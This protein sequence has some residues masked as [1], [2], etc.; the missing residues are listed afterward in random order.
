MTTEYSGAAS[1]GAAPSTSGQPGSNSGSGAG[2]TPGVPLAELVGITKTFGALV[3]NDSIDL[4]VQPGEVLALLGENGAGKST[5]T[6]ILYGLSQADRGEIRINGVP[7]RM[8]SP[9]DAMAAGIGMVTQEFSL[10]GTMTVTENLMLAGVG[11]GRI[12]RAEARERVLEA[13][14]RIGVTIDPDA[15]VEN[16]SVGERQRVEIVKALFHNCRL[17]ILDEPTAVL[18]PQDVAVLFESIRRLTADGMGVIFI[19]HK[20][21]EVV[22]I[23]NRVSILRRGRIVASVPAAGLQPAQIAAMMVGSDAAELSTSPASTGTSV[24]LTDERAAALA[25]AIGFDADANTSDTNTSDAND[26]STSGA[27]TPI[28]TRTALAI[29]DLTLAGD[30]KPLLD[31]I[32]ITVGAGEIVGV[33]GVSGNGQTELVSVLCGTTPATSGTVLVGDTTIT[34]L[35]V[36]DRIRAGLGRLTEDRRGSVVLNLS[37]EQNLVLEDLDQFRRGPFLD[38]RRIRAHVRELISRFDIRANAS[39]PIRTL[40]GGNMQKVLLARAIAR[41]PTALV[42]SQPTRGLDV[43]ACDYVYSQLRSLRDAGAGVL[44]VSEDLD[45]LLDLCDRVVVLFSGRVIGEVD[46]AHAS[47]QQLGLLMTGHTS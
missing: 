46:A 38:R 40:S 9:A 6:R 36:A 34:D 28:P 42:A 21:H 11:L 32:T 41:G 22:A 47:R 29:T 20:L 37:V 14:A 13:A 23:A 8:S 25:T 44:L 17:L 30:A 18:V 27:N 19:S 35:P 33:A 39:D 1:Q 3:A 16:L 2:S 7:T 26:V 15:I 10:V 24:P 43:G 31:G 4:T 12:H 45:E 5:L